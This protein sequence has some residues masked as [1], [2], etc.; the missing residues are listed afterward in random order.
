MD[1]IWPRGVSKTRL[2]I[3]GWARDIAPSTVLRQWFGHDPDKWE[4]FKEHYFRE[5]DRCPDAIQSLLSRARAE[6]VTLV[7]GAK[8]VRYNNAVALKEYLDRQITQ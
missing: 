3:D 2:R 6:R 1:R 5:L 8:D 4:A 7:F